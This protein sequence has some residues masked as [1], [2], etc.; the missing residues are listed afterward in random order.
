M[1]QIA[2]SAGAKVVE[3]GG[4][5]SFMLMVIVALVWFARALWLQ[6]K[7]QKEEMIAMVREFGDVVEKNTKAFT[8]FSERIEHVFRKDK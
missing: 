3:Y 2:V 4:L 1:D 5:V 6:N 8:I 7:E